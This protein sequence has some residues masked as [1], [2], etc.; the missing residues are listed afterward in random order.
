MNV[1]APHRVVLFA[2]V[3]AL[4]AVA[5]VARQGPPPGATVAPAARPAAEPLP[6]L[7]GIED[8][9]PSVAPARQALERDG[10]L[11]D[12]F[13]A[14]GQQ[15]DYD[16]QAERGELCL[17]ELVAAGY[18]RGWTMA[19]TLRV[20]THD[21]QVLVERASTGGVQM[22]TFLA[23][24]APASGEYRLRVIPTE[25]TF[26]YALVRH[27]SYAPHGASPRWVGARERLH[28]WVAGDTE[29]VLYAVPVRAGEVLALSVE[30]TRAAARAE[31]RSLL[32]A[33]ADG[34]ASAMMRAAPEDGRERASRPA[35]FPKLRL[36]VLGDT[37]PAAASPTFALLP[38]AGADGVVQVEVG[39]APGE[40]GGLLDLVVRRDV[41]CHALHGVV[42][43][44]DDAP[45]AGVD[46]RFLLEPDLEP[47]G[48]GVTD[49]QGA[50]A[51][52]VPAGDYRVEL[53][54]S[55]SGPVQAA[56][57]GV[58]T[59]GELNLMWRDR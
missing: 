56:R 31:R 17:F 30:G 29:R 45:L 40:P 37:R 58:A 32:A 3:G 38:P 16:L 5:V 41:A 35:R 55:A 59:A 8:P 24:Q 49:A 20:T 4:V 6:A 57:A 52:R 9:D 2:L 33:Q 15:A 47:W 43:D 1:F 22:H 54:R 46:V 28:D 21:E 53:R 51:V 27:G 48:R 36:E 39:V 13:T 14:D 12:R 18:A 7:P 23:F 25:S 11:L 26:R 42:V 34:A 44:A 50:Y 19:A 10:V